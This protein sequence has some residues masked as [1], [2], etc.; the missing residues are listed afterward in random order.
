MIYL[1]EILADHEIKA[2]APCRLDVG[3]TWD[4]KPFALLYSHLPPTTT[5]MALN[6]RTHVRL[7]PYQFGWV[8]VADEFEEEKFPADRMP[9]DSHFKLLFAVLSHFSVHGVS[10][11][12]SYESPPQS[13]LGGSGTLAVTTIAALEEACVS[14][15]RPRMSREGIVELA[16]NIEDGLR[17]SYTGMQ[18]QCAAV[19]GGVNRWVWTYNSNSERAPFIREEILGTD[20]YP[21]LESRLL[22]AYLGKSH[23]SSEVNEMQVRSF[24]EGRSRKV[25]FRINEIAIEF[26]EAVKTHDWERAASLVSEENRLRYEMVPKRLTSM[27]VRL[28]EVA[29]DMGAGFAAA[30]AG[31]GGCVWALCPDPSEVNR[32][33]HEWEGILK[34]AEG[35]GL[36]DVRIDG[37][38][39]SVQR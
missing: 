36:L 4:L 32:L 37:S 28:M 6:M 9:F 38:G 18:D 34:E 11:E 3:G 39:L 2:S 24:L 13:G 1:G 25:W 20:G 23:I 17:F 12:L 35:A 8:R 5:N 22:L 29:E 7:K 15:G 27:A 26:A 10:V 19:Y 16:H 31:G 21:E 30:G 33:K 14:R